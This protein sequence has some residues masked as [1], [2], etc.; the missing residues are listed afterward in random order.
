MNHDQQL[1]QVYVR[2]TPRQREVLQLVSEGLSN[3]QVASQLCIAPSVV[4]GHLTCIY[5]TLAVLAAAEKRP[6][7]YQLI[8]WYGEFF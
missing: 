5:D 8:R 7:R 3:Q 2:L 1:V 6:G 4:A